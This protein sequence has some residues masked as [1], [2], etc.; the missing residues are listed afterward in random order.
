VPYGREVHGEPSDLVNY[1]MGSHISSLEV[2]LVQPVSGESVQKEFLDSKGEGINHLCF[3]VDDIEEATSI[4]ADEGFEPVSSCKF[5]GGG[6]MS[7]FDT[8]KVGGVLTE[9]VEWPEKS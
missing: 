6:G 5:K 1:A 8:D 2:E 9:L 3:Q 7:Y 4:M